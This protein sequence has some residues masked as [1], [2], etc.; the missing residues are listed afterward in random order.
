MSFPSQPSGSD[1][2]RSRPQAVF[3]QTSYN[4]IAKRAAEAGL[5]QPSGS[6]LTPLAVGESIPL[7]FCK[8]TADPTGGVFLSPK[9]AKL[10]F[11]E[12]PSSEDSDYDNV[13]VLLPFD[14]DDTDAGPADVN[15]TQVGTALFSSS[16]AKYGESWGTSDGASNYLRIPTAALDMGGASNATWTLEFWVYLTS[17]NTIQYILA[18]REGATQKFEFYKNFA[19][20]VFF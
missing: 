6:G 7:V 14:G 16:I 1:Q 11:V 17:T 8:R 20:S 9:A 2:V 18:R 5:L 3:S 13:Q 12:T 4:E 15:V 10:K 19:H